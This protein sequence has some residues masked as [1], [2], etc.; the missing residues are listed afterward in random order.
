MMFVDEH[1]KLS[2]HKSVNK[3]EA[4]DMF[5][6]YH[7]EYGGYSPFVLHF[8][9]ATH[10]KIGIENCHPFYAGPD[11][12]I[13]HN[14]I[15]NNIGATTSGERSDTRIFAEEF[16]S[17]LPRNWY[18]NIGTRRLVEALIGYSKIVMLNTDGHVEIINPEYGEWDKET[19]RWFSGS[20]WKTGHYYQWSWDEDDIGAGSYCYTAPQQNQTITED[21]LELVHDNIYVVT[22]TNYYLKKIGDRSYVQASIMEEL[23]AKAAARPKLLTLPTAQSRTLCRECGQLV[24]HALFDTTIDRCRYCSADWMEFIDPEG[25][26]DYNTETLYIEQ[27]IAEGTL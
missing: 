4:Q 2:I 1:K 20:S 13:V 27:C 12:A 8:R 10:G 23:D 3:T 17:Y 25:A 6:Y 16:L 21:S 18:R 24:A 15:I 14:G 7:D 22:G 26:M 19:G 11:S 5:K 9:I